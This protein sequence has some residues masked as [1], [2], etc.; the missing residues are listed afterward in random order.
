MKNKQLMMSIGL[1]ALVASCSIEKKEIQ[2]LNLAKYE[3]EDGRCILFIG[4]DIEATGGGD[5][6]RGYIDYFDMPAG[7]TIYTNI[8]PGD[9]SFGHTYT[10]LD[11]LTSNANWGAGNCYADRLLGEERFA[12][13][14]IAIGLELVNHE[15]R[16]ASGEHDSYI[17]SLANWVKATNRP[18]FL[19]IGYEF[20]GHEWNHYDSTAYVQAYRRIK[21]KFTDY[22]VDNVAYVWQS[23]GVG[24]TAED[25]NA[26]YPGDE[27]VDWVSYSQFGAGRCQI[28]IDFARK[29]N[30][31]LF[32]AEATPM[33]KDNSPLHLGNEQEG[34]KAWDTWFAELINTV[35]ENDDVIKAVSYINCNWEIQP[36]WI[37]N[38]VFSN[39]DA[40][41]QENPMIS[42]G[43]NDW[44]GSTSFVKE[45]K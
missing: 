29:K 6:V 30:K 42:K 37:V 32:I 3:P 7:L 8:R 45:V 12:N 41:L 28:M 34:Q 35:E 23:K 18:V 15:E 40:R 17:Y 38:P 43:W 21:D 33:F 20:D 19:R 25:I 16:V 22:G 4:Q 31:P 2:T 14:A 39:I 10:G 13:T 1:I 26:Y 11:G 36:M 44:I 27:Y 9:T 5:S 24:T